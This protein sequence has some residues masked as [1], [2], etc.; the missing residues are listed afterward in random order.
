MAKSI[1]MEGTE[2]STERSLAEISA[3]LMEFGAKQILTEY[4]DRQ[5]SSISFRLEIE[6]Q[7]LSFRLPCRWK[8]ILQYFQ[9]RR[10]ATMH[11]EPIENQAKRVAWRQILR[12]LQAQLALLDTKMVEPSEVFLPYMQN[13]K[14]KT[15]FEEIKGGGYKMLGGPTE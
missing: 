9:A 5:I 12:W 15:L 13:R 4:E 7:I 1:F 11:K 2:I 6:G 14:G 10:M 3:I 8:V